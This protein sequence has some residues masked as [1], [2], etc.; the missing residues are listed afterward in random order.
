MNLQTDPRHETSTHDALGAFRPIPYMGVIYVVAE[1]MKLGYRNGHPDWCNLGQGQPEVGEIEGAPPRISS[2]PVEPADHAYGPVNGIG[3]LRDAIA[4]HYNR[5]YR[6]GKR[7]QYSAENVTVACGGR[8]VLSRL[9]AALA[10]VRLGH[11]VPD[12]TAYED[13]IAYHLSRLSAV[14]LRAREEDGF[15]I[16][17]ARLEREIREHG[18]EAFVL[19]NPCNPTGRVI[20]GSELEAYVELARRSSCT[21][22]LD[23]FYSHFV[24]D[25]ERPGNGP[26][27][28]AAFVED[29]DRDPVILVDGL[30]KSFRYPGW[31]VGW[32]LGPRGMVDA[33]TRAA[34]AIDGGPS[35]PVQRAAVRVLEPERADAES[36]ALRATFVRKRNLML[37]RLQRMGIRCT[38]PSEGTF[39]Q[40]GSIERCPKELRRGEVFFRRAL[41]QKVL[42]VPGSFFDVDPGRSRKGP[43]AFDSW[44]RFSF[45][46]PEENVR[47]GLDR[48]EALLRDA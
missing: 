36:R 25:G 9:F 48:L 34:S 1:A 46:P 19:S 47:T 37:E 32:A 20:R 5:L 24:Y 23:E 39:Y 18:L 8:L 7:S 42:T 3:E 33:L 16:P 40:W 44:V 6:R 10:G 35:V 11:Q 45:G 26:V 12:Y 15:G 43:S 31:R 2:F 17:A 13:M 38:P 27:S 22:I 14:A 28:A 41:E 21:L 4:Q 29:V 30:T